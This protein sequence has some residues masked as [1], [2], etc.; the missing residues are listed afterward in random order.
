M[1][2]INQSETYS[3]SW[4]QPPFDP[5]LRCA[6]RVQARPWRRTPVRSLP[7][8][9]LHPLARRPSPCSTASPAMASTPPP[10]SQSD[11][12]DASS[13][14]AAVRADAVAQR[15]AQEKANAA[16]AAAQRAERARQEARDAALA[17]VVQ[18]EDEAKAAA[19][20]RDAAAQRASDALARAAKERAAAAVAI[21]PKSSGAPPGGAPMPDLHAAMLHHEAMALLQLH[22]K[23]VAVSNIQNHVTTILDVDSGN[24]S[25]WCDQFLL[26]LSKF[27]L[28]DH[29]R[30][31]PPDPIS[32][33]WARMDCV[34]K[35]WIIATLTDDL[36]E[37]I[38]ARGSTARHAW[39]AVK[40][41]FLGNREARSIQLETRFRNFV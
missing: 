23:A 16:A 2:Y 40:S 10:T 6:T 28:Q 38:S 7:K 15:L 25:R 9:A 27:S 21:T 33:D 8:R 34:V 35:S 18:A 11:A 17:R 14:G 29:V 37:I 41:Q 22:S 4:Y 5:F 13:A 39:L 32:P 36:G 30:E 31:D 1:Q 12:T 3:L 24:F 19:A 26:I 20:E